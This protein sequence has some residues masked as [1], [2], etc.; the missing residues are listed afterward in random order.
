MRSGGDNWSCKTSKVPVKSSTSTNQHQMFYRQD[1]LP[2]TQPTGS[3]HRREPNL[4]WRQYRCQ[5]I[6][7]TGETDSWPLDWGQIKNTTQFI[8]PLDLTWRMPCHSQRNTRIRPVFFI[9]FC[10]HLAP[11]VLESCCHIFDSISVIHV[12]LGHPVPWPCGFHCCCTSV[13]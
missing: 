7:T 12:F 8:V 11:A 9:Q 4:Q 3:E 2:V 1:S 13:R 5:L 6:V 10:L